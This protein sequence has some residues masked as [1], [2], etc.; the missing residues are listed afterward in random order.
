MGALEDKVR[1]ARRNATSMEASIAANETVSR[2]AKTAGVNLSM[3]EERKA[4]KVLKPRI[5]LDRGKT[6]ARGMAILKT[7]E[8]KAAAK[9]IAAATGNVP[10]TKSTLASAAKKDI[11]FMKDVKPKITKAEKGI[12]K[13]LSPKGV[14]KAEKMQKGAIDKKYPGMF[15]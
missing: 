12:A 15:K 8:K 4:A 5:K 2:N 3:A 10:K 7:Q 9:R 6:A 14:K 1:K 11:K 13:E